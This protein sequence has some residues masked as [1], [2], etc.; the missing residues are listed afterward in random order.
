M[1][2]PTPAAAPVLREPSTRKR[3]LSER[4]Q[5]AQANLEAAEAGKRKRSAGPVAV[6]E[7]EVKE[8]EE[9]EE[10]V[11]KKRAT[12]RQKEAT[13]A[14]I[15]QDAPKRP[16]GRP[17]KFPRQATSAAVAGSSQEGKFP[18]PRRVRPLVRS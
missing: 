4:A 8:E 10:P 18:I 15:K 13:P 11:A 7:W 16:V 12:S 17:R 2:A 1:R 6:E 14:P 3:K 5:E 9:E